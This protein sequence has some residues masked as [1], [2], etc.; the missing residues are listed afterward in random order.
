MNESI[1]YLLAGA[2]GAMLFATLVRHFAVGNPGRRHA[3]ALVVA[4]LL[5]VAFAAHGGSGDGILIE[6]AGVAV[7][8]G[9]ALLGLTRR[10]PALLALGWALHPV[11]DVALHST[12][13]GLQYTPHGYVP[14]C[15]GFDLLLAMLIALGWAYTPARARIA[16]E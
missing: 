7:F 12:G 9:I 14:A 1:L 4:A 3:T 5:Y 8:G 13:A 15:I 2:A 11:W 6:A 16:A 10:A